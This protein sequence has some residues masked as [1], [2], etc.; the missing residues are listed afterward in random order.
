M[1]RYRKLAGLA[2]ACGSMLVYTGTGR[3]GGEVHND[4][5]V[6]ASVASNCSSITGLATVDFSG[7]DAIAGNEKTT[8]MQKTSSFDVTCTLGSALSITVS[9]GSNLADDAGYRHVLRS[10]G[11]AAHYAT[12]DLLRYIVYQPD[13]DRSTLTT[14]EWGG[15]ASTAL[16]SGATA[17]GDIGT[18]VSEHYVMFFVAPKGQNVH[19]G[20]NYGSETLTVQVN[21]T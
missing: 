20:S 15:A 12:G 8:D 17:Y 18:G 10:G 21:Y 13:T 7:Y 9:D 3:A 19:T 14:N 6:N 2:L 16:T 5:T 1:N 11:D 4:V